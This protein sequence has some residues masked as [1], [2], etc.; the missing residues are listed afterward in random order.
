MRPSGVILPDILAS[1][2][3]PIVF[4]ILSRVESEIFRNQSENSDWE[5]FQIISSDL[6]SPR[7]KINSEQEV[8]KAACD[9][10]LS[11]AS[12]YRLFTSK[13]TFS[14]INNLEIPGLVC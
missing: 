9:F 7:I 14:I 4:H 12:A 5:G 6:I 10:T 8:D 1:D 3:P 13:V 2:H 11:I